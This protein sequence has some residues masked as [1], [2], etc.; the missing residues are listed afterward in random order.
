[1]SDNEKSTI[2]KVKDL[3][4]GKFNSEDVEK[5]EDTFAEVKTS[6]GV[7][8]NV[9]AMEAGATIEV[10]SEDGKELAP[11]GEYILED[12]ST[13]VVGEAGI[14]SEVK[15][16]E[17]NVEEDV[18]EDMEAVEE[19]VEVEVSEDVESSLEARLDALE[20]TLNAKFESV[21]AELKEA[22]EKFASVN[23]LQ[24]NEL[25]ELKGKFSAFKGEPAAEEIKI[26]KKDAKVSKFQALGN[27]RRN[28]K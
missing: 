19:V 14:V 25:D 11:A 2:E 5:V 24:A 13:I 10:V 22:N 23:E 15:E 6:E 20:E 17:E 9:S 27:I 1:M 21:I 16:A 26:S 8:L 7:I 12:G 3:L 4:S 28:K 18:A